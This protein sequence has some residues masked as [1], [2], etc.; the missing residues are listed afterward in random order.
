MILVLLYKFVCNARKVLPV[1]LYIIK[2]LIYHFYKLLL[3]V[4]YKYKLFCLLLFK[5]FFD[6][7]TQLFLMKRH[8]T[9]CCLARPLSSNILTISHIQF[10]SNS[11]QSL[12]RVYWEPIIKMFFLNKS[13]NNILIIF[14]QF[15]LYFLI[16]KWTQLFYPYYSHIVL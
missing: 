9:S 4:H 8:Y 5:G 15:I 11:I 14:R 3:W 12:Y 13:D 1:L 7:L 2:I 6:N 10:F 16:R